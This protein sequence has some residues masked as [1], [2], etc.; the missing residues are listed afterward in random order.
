MLILLRRLKH[1]Y[2]YTN[3]WFNVI[4]INHSSVSCWY[5]LYLTTLAML[6]DITNFHC[7]DTQCPVL[8]IINQVMGTCR[9]LNWCEKLWKRLFIIYRDFNWFCKETHNYK[10][11]VSIIK[12]KTKGYIIK[13]RT[14]VSIS[15]KTS[16][17]II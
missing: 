12:S 14:L 9:V 4:N 11:F 7:P 16:R 10:K 15:V 3:F 1:F 6:I 2:M 13:S 8:S 5:I 17:N